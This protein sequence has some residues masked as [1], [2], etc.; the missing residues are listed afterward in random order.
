MYTVA[1]Q[2]EFTARHFLVGGDW[3]DENEPHAHHYVAEVRLEGPDLATHGYLD[4][5]PLEAARK[6]E[7]EFY[8]FME[9]EY[10][11]VGHSIATTKDLDEN[12]EKKLSEAIAKFKEQFKAKLPAEPELECPT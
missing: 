1:V 2:R 3:G 5:L 9:N 6:F 12:T 10:P 8:P 7:E 11:D 4:D